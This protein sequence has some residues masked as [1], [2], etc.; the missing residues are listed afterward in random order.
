MHL[1]SVEEHAL[2][3]ASM[4]RAVKY[5]SINDLPSS[6]S[7]KKP[8]SNKK[9]D[10]DSKTEDRVFV[11]LGRARDTGQHHAWVMTISKDFDSVTLWEPTL[12]Q[13][14]HLPGRV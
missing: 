8:K 12:G 5:E 9:P 14:F 2:L 7:I 3:M 11:C 1:A 6:D 4:F 13:Q 10:E